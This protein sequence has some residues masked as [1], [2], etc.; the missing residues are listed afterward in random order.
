MTCGVAEQSMH[1]L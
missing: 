1:F